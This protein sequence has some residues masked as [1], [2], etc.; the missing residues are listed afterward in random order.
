[1]S[2]KIKVELPAYGSGQKV[3]QRSMVAAA[4]YRAGES[5]Q[6]EQLG[7][8]FDYTHKHNVEAS[9]MLTPEY[10]KDWT[11]DRQRYWNTVENR[12]KRED[13]FFV[14]ET[15]LMLPR[16]LN[17][18]QRKQVVESWANENLVMK[19]DLV[20]DYAIHTPNASHEKYHAHV[21]YYPHPI[22]ENGKF[23]DD[24]HNVETVIGERV[25]TII[26]L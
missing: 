16:D 17:Q 19:R 26:I 12:E 20:V 15:I 22:S 10:A 5:L 3:N 8:T 1:M 6:D 7:K 21:F 9:A 23:V 18:N 11:K 4:A 13:G 2:E 14:K 25:P 24:D